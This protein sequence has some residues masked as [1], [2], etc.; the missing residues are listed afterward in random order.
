MGLAFCHTLPRDAILRAAAGLCVLSWLLLLIAI[1]D[2][3]NRAKMPWFTVSHA[4]TDYAITPWEVMLKSEQGKSSRST[5]C[6]NSVV[7]RSSP[8]FSAC[9]D[10][11]MTGR[12]MVGLF[13]IADIFIFVLGIIVSVIARTAEK[14]TRLLF[15]Y[16]TCV[17]FPTLFC[18]AAIAVAGES[19]VP[20]LRDFFKAGTSGASVTVKLSHG[21]NLCIAASVFLSIAF[22]MTVVKLLAFMRE[23]RKLKQAIER[24]ASMSRS[25]TVP[26]ES[27]ACV[28]ER[29]ANR[30]VND[31]WER[32][33][34][35][36]MERRV[37]VSALFKAQPE[38]RAPRRKGT[39]PPA[40]TSSDGDRTTMDDAAAA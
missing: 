19:Y 17:F 3:A 20:S 32:Q 15:G 1:A 5:L 29:L 11:V 10:V 22:I 9:E 30:V 8:V 36:W 25:A 12:T 18:I 40:A 26:V 27:A 4:N 16:A 37:A 28:E 21:F 34:A 24:K 13:A 31:D 23:N 6:P 39:P 35:I 33:K 2:G 7:P 38:L 14:N